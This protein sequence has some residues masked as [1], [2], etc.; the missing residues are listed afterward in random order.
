MERTS[1]R[2]IIELL[3]QLNVMNMRSC[4]AFYLRRDTYEYGN[5]C[6]NTAFLLAFDFS[7]LLF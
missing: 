4:K 5:S 6:E 2:R 1:I 3:K 7:S